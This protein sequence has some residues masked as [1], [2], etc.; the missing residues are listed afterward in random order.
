ML[1][2]NVEVIWPIVWCEQPL[3][4]TQ[5]RK[6][7]AVLLS[8]L[9]VRAFMCWSVDWKDPINI[10]SWGLQC[11]PIVWYLK[12]R[13]YQGLDVS[14]GLFLS[15]GCCSRQ[16]IF[17]AWL[18]LS[19]KIILLQG[20]LFHKSIQTQPSI[21]P[22]CRLTFW[23]NQGSN[24]EPEAQ[25]MYRQVAVGFHPGAHQH[26]SWTRSPHLSSM[27]A[28]TKAFL[29]VHFHDCPGCVLHF[30][31]SSG[32]C[33]SSAPYSDAGWSTKHVCNR[34]QNFLHFLAWLMLNLKRDTERSSSKDLEA[35]KL[36]YFDSQQM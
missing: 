19:K 12:L 34:T 3:F 22:S 28:D 8:L 20:L 7:R 5:D 35:Q 30:H 4:C 1:S 32:S 13:E 16:N 24:W 2:C 23:K 6:A 29:K 11:L 17:M 9:C 18:I 36:K 15:Q 31:S 33:Q 27:S 26:R 10:S 21:Q 25:D 14:Y